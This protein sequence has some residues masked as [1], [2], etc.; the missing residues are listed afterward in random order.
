V[1]SVCMSMG[2]DF[3]TVA[4]SWQSN[5]TCYVVIPNDGQ[6]PVDTYRRHEI[7]HATPCL[8]LQARQCWT[9]HPI[10]GALPRPSQSAIHRKVHGASRR[11]VHTILERLTR[12]GPDESMPGHPSGPFTTTGPLRSSDHGYGKKSRSFCQ[13]I[14]GNNQ[15]LSSSFLTSVSNPG[16][17]SLGTS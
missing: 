14:L 2:L 12:S 8:W 9:R 6:A 16:G 11:P 5:D 7:A 17:N 10:A 4:C 13:L 3:L 1:R 15:S